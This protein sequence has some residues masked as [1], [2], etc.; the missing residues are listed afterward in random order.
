VRIAFP[1]GLVLTVLSALSAGCARDPGDGLHRQLAIGFDPSTRPL[2]VGIEVQLAIER[3]RERGHFCGGNCGLDRK[4]EPLWI[5]RVTSSR[6]DRIEVLGIDDHDPRAPLVRLAT[7]A[8]GETVV[9]VEAASS[10]GSVAVADAWTLEARPL[11]RIDVSATQLPENARVRL[12]LRPVAVDGRELYVGPI[13]ARLSGDGA[14]LW[15]DHR[16]AVDVETGAAG[17]ATLELTSAQRTAKVPL[18]IGR[19]ALGAASAPG[20]PRS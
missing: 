15:A 13:T 20:K 7:R 10:G 3:P 17:S 18:R 12:D 14:R 5:T 6:P 1:T 2:A 8:P 16:A 19:T 4:L 9:T 11:S